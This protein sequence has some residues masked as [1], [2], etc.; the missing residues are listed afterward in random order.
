M[1]TSTVTVSLLYLQG[2]TRTRNGCYGR[3]RTVTSRQS[4]ECREIPYANRRATMTFA[5]KELQTDAK[6]RKEDTASPF[7]RAILIELSYVA[8][9]KRNCGLATFFKQLPESQAG[10]L[11]F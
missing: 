6:G 1:V 11:E 3:R 9:G 4:R 8:F 7:V 5:S 2:Y 10:R